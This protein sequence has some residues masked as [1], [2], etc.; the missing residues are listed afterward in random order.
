MATVTGIRE[1][2]RRLAAIGDT[3]SMLRAIQI[4][5]VSEAQ[6]R[7]P[8]KTGHLQRSI[9]PGRVTDDSAIIEAR[10]PYAAAVEFGSKPHIIRPKNRQALAWPG[11]GGRRL[12][13][14]RRVN[15]GPLTFAKV[16]HHPGT[17]AQPYLIPGAKAAVAKG[18]GKDILITKWN[19]AA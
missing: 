1:L 10:T 16:V 4:A 15:S 3:R 11:A 2:E 19:R 13:G 9:R 17:R 14:R 5:A 6:S 12:S 7:V 18:G 8:R